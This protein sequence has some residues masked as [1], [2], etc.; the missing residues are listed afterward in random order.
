MADPINQQNP[1]NQGPFDATQGQGSLSNPDPN[2]SQDLAGNRTPLNDDTLYSIKTDQRLDTN[3]ND[4]DLSNDPAAANIDPNDDQYD[5]Q[6][7]QGLY[8]TSGDYGNMGGYMKPA[9]NRDRYGT[10]VSQDQNGYQ[11]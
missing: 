10:K 5:I 6:G 1:S 11:Q 8:G 2:G 7:G 4:Q 9:S 3:Q